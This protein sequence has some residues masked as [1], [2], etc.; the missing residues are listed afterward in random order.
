MSE[1]ATRTRTQLI[2]EK[3]HGRNFYQYICY[4][5]PRYRFGDYQLTVDL[6]MLYIIADGFGREVIAKWSEY[7]E[8]QTWRLKLSR[9]QLGQLPR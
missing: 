6:D 7:E 9:F 1:L 4:W 8:H 2:I 5:L 3:G